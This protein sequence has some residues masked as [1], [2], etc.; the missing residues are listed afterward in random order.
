MNA[1]TVPVRRSIEVLSGGQHRGG[2]GGEAVRVLR[3]LL[4]ENSV[5]W[6]P[7]P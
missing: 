5:G 4:L 6:V 3:V 1:I 7:S 2:S